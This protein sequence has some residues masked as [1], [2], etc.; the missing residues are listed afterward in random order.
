MHKLRLQKGVNMYGKE[1]HIVHTN[2]PCPLFEVCI[3]PVLLLTTWQVD[4]EV[5]TDSINILAA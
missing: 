1:V 3:N 2:A 5:W 4:T